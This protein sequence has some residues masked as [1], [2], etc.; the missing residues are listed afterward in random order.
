MTMMIRRVPMANMHFMGSVWD[1]PQ[2]NFPGIP[3]W[4]LLL[5]VTVALVANIHRTSLRPAAIVLPASTAVPGCRF[6]ATVQPERIKTALVRTAARNAQVGN[7]HM[8]LLLRRVP[9]RART[10]SM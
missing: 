1:V 8:E 6:V 2:E 9:L 3:F 5:N 4:A 7:Q 10:G